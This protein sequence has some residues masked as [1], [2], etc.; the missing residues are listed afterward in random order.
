MSQPLD[1]PGV[2]VH[3]DGFDPDDTR[4]WT[5]FPDGAA[6]L[7]QRHHDL[8]DACVAWAMSEGRDLDPD[9][10]AVLC[11]AAEEGFN[12]GDVTKWTVEPAVSMWLWCSTILRVASTWL[13]SSIRSASTT[14]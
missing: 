1:L 13:S 14:R 3:R 2:I 7:R 8:I 5:P 12:G 11:G 10:V 6:Y 4:P 9:V